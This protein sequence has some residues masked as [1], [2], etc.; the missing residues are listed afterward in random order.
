VDV[1]AES[2]EAQEDTNPVEVAD[3]AIASLENAIE[4][5]YQPCIGTDG[6]IADECDK[7]ASGTQ[8]QRL[9]KP[10]IHNCGRALQ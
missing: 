10:P 8:P 4:H 1:E 2:L 5:V 9:M 3:Q 6:L 7:A